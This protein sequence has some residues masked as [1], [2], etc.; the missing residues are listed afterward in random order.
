MTIVGHQIIHCTCTE[1]YLGECAGSASG[2]G[3]SVTP[4][5][6]INSSKSVRAA[7]PKLHELL[8]HNPYAKIN[9]TLYK[10]VFT[11]YYFAIHLP[12]LL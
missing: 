8:T 2:T 10:Q 6:E 9:N 7:V 4:T 12:C 11:N 3:Y 5:S 1:E